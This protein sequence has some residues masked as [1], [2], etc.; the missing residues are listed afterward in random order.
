MAPPTHSSGQPSPS[1]PAGDTM[2]E[3]QAILGIVFV[4]TAASL[5]SLGAVLTKSLLEEFSVVEMALARTISTC[6]FLLIIVAVYYRAHLK[7]SLREVP[8]AIAYGTVAMVLSPFM[9]FSAIE[10]VSVGIVLIIGYSAPLLIILWLRVVRKM[11]IAPPTLA[12]MG[13]CLFGLALAAAPSGGI[14]LDGTG[15]LYACGGAVTM[16]TFFLLAERALQRRPAVVVSLFGHI[17]GSL[18]WLL[19]VPAWH[20][21]FE[22]LQKPMALPSTLHLPLLPASL[23]IP[24]IALLCAVTPGILW[25]SGVK[26]LGPAR[27]S[28]ISMIEPIFAAAIA[29]LLLSEILSP[30][31]MTGGAIALSGLIYLEGPWRKRPQSKA[32]LT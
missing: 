29:W 20:F 12:G 24:A 18:L 25:L 9:F 5:Y 4:A 28:A 23:L 30:M 1:Y 3:R 2:L 17:V 10:R 8:L 32:I 6:V 16:A 19:L 21:P 22:L 31:Q 26:F 7:L 15:L 13:I 27:A 11:R 14:A